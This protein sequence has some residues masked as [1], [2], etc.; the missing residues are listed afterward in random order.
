MTR[1][2]LAAKPRF[3]P[4]VRTRERC[5]HCNGSGFWLE[6]YCGFCDGAGVLPINPDAASDEA[7]EARNRAWN[8]GRPTGEFDA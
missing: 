6:A 1:Q 8:L 5:G 2:A 3:S 7:E 4:I